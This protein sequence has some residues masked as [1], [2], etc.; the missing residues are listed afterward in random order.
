M[1]NKVCFIFI[2][3]VHICL[4]VCFF[5]TF[6]PHIHRVKLCFYLGLYINSFV[7]LLIFVVVVFPCVVYVRFSA[8]CA[9]YFVT[10]LSFYSCRLI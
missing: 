2:L 4:Y 3:H 8:K 9:L 10:I 6:L 5:F 1:K 7:Y